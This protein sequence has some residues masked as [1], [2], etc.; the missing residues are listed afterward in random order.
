MC[1]TNFGPLSAKV[2]L[3][4][5]IDG[6]GRSDT[7]KPPAR[8]RKIGSPETNS[9]HVPYEH[10]D[11]RFE[12]Y[13]R[14]ACTLRRV[15]VS[16]RSLAGKRASGVLVALRASFDVLLVRAALAA[17]VVSSPHIHLVSGSRRFLMALLAC[18]HMLFM[19]A[20]LTAVGRLVLP[21]FRRGSCWRI[22]VA[23]L[24]SSHVIFV[25]A[26]SDRIFCQ[27]VAPF[28]LCPPTSGRSRSANSATLS[29]Q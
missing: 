2:S 10:G 4:R 14:G 22:L 24:T 1:P 11:E 25:S 5:A 3:L 17:G 18:L 26:I 9:L 13:R 19:R 28:C 6:T 8:V 23:L 7:G 12:S 16:L 15:D 27:G 21:I 29:R 20:T